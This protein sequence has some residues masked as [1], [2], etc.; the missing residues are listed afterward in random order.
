MKTPPKGVSLALA[1]ALAGSL[2]IATP[3]SAKGTKNAKGDC[4]ASSDWKLK[5]ADKKGRIQVTATV[6]SRKGG[7]TW[8]WK[9][10]HNGDL[11]DSGS[12][13]M[14]KSQKVLNVKRK[15]VNLSGKD[16]IV[17]TAENAGTDESCR[18]TL[19]K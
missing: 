13:T 4:S 17:F 14:K 16:G 5:A 10:Y 9:L 2:S 19:S 15:M 7:Q 6:K 11:S 8:V 3:A 18:G 1:L 12:K